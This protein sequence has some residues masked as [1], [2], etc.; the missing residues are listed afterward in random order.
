[1]A[2]LTL[3]SKGSTGG[4]ALIESLNPDFN[5][6]VTQSLRAGVNGVNVSKALLRFDLSS[7]PVNALVSSAILTLHTVGQDSSIGRA[8][9][10]TRGLTQWYEGSAD[11][12]IPT[13]NGSTWSKRNYPFNV[14]WS[15]SVAG[16]QSGVDYVASPSGGSVVIN[17]VGIDYSWTVTA[18][19]QLWANGTVN[20]GWWLFGTTA[21]TDSRK[22]FSSFD[23]TT[24]SQR[25]KLVITYTSDVLVAP[26][27]RFAV[28]GRAGPTVVKGAITKAP[29]ADSSVGTTTGPTVKAG[30]TLT[31]SPA[32][33]VADKVDPNVGVAGLT[34]LGGV[35]S[36]RGANNEAVVPP[37][38]A[39]SL[40]PAP[41]NAKGTTTGPSAVIKG[42]P[43]LTPNPAEA[44]GETPA[45]ASLVDLTLRPAAATAAGETSVTVIAARIY[46]VVCT[47]DPLLYITNGTLRSNGQ[48]NRLSLLTTGFLLNDWKPNISQYKDGGVWS[49]SALA[50]GRTLAR[51]SFANALE[52]MDMR[53]TGKDQ[54]V[55]IAFMQELFAWQELA[56]DYWVSDW[57]LQPVYLVTK[58]AK[59]TNIR[60]ALIKAMSVPELTNPFG[61]PFYSRNNRSVIDPFTL[62][63]ERG[64]WLST[65]P[66]LGDCVN[67]SG[68]R[69]WTVQG[70]TV[71]NTTGGGAA[72]ISGAVLCF[73]QLANGDILAGTN[74]QAQIYRSTN[75]GAS[76]IQIA[77]LGT[78]SDAINKMAVTRAG[79]I[80]AAV[81]GSTAARGIW[82]SP[83][84]GTS[85]A[86]TYNDPAGQGYLDVGYAPGQ[87]FLV[88][89]GGSS[90]AETNN[91]IFSND[92]G[93]H[94][95]RSNDVPTPYG[96][97]AIAFQ[98]EPVLATSYPNQPASA[99]NVQ[100]AGFWGTDGYYTTAGVA[101]MDAVAPTAS[102]T[103]YSHMYTP[104][105][106]Q[107]GNGGLDM[108][109]FLHKNPQGSYYRKALWAV[110]SALDVTDTE[111]WQWPNPAGGFNFGKLATI[112][113]KIFNVLYTDPVA[114]TSIPTQRTIWAGA[115]GE[116]YVSYNNGLTWTLATSAPVNQIRAILRT[117]AGTLITGGDSGEVFVYSGASG[118]TGGG[119]GAID[120]N[121]RPINVSA[122]SGGSAVVN[123]YA[124]GMEETCEDEVY[125]SNKSSFSNITHVLHYNGSTYTELQFATLPPYSLLGTTAV[126]N[127]AA[128]FG[129]KTSD[130]NVP[131]GTF[132]SVIFEISQIA[133]NITVVWEFWNGSAWVSLTV[134]D[135]STGFRIAGVGSVHFTVPVTWATTTVNGVLG[136]W[137]RA[138]ISV[139]GT[140]PVTPIHDS[141]HHR[142]IYTANLPYVEISQAGVT[143][144]LP[145]NAQIRWHNRS[146]DPLTVIDLE[147]DR[148]VCGLRSV[149]R[150]QYFN[151]FLNISDKQIPYGITIAKDVDGSFGDSLRAPT[152]RIL[153]V[154]YSSGGRLNTWND[155]AV[156]SISNTVARDY[157][158]TYRAFVRCYKYG[159][160]TNN[161]QL[162][163]QTSF[164]TGGN[165]T[166]SKA[167]FPGTGNDWEVLDFGQITI[168]TTQV[169]FLSS[170]LGDALSLS[171]QGYCTATGIG[172]SLYD[173]ILIPCDE[174][175]IDS[176]SPNPSSS[177]VAKVKGDS[178][179]DVDSIT[180]PKTLITSINRNGSDQIV[181]RYQAITN[182]P[183]MLQT[184][185][186]QRLW[187]LIM[188]YEGY[189]RAYPE[190]AGSVQAYKQQKYLYARGAS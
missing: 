9:G 135:T 162:R 73:V 23:A 140:N 26:T 69:S 80:V 146:D 10:V 133:E 168:P 93:I 113:N 96:I 34:F 44:V 90:V 134:Q 58:A 6:G 49:D 110:K 97:K 76:W 128:Y 57:G 107:M 72:T 106:G 25:P 180:S 103:P 81:T 132:S 70:W 136:Y 88:A 59:E 38:I 183:A 12:A 190:I 2:V 68:I 149:N 165:V 171:V 74:D 92:E 120:E 105:S 1:M 170:N 39:A 51:R 86:K 41:A 166:L 83:G 31:P 139:V 82:R 11:N 17:T 54:D 172:L 104:G 79:S 118:S 116:L 22:H 71:G 36:A 150:G 62:R 20:N 122:P 28:A 154:S 46:P 137:V 43:H 161:W 147:I 155:L 114:Y 33:A 27:A 156:F 50:E 16:G 13:G 48:L 8:I 109:V 5:F 169:A 124:L 4:D 94:W 112:D 32:S 14:N 115:N 89:V 141:L 179:L 66:G 187:F 40:A 174:W 152:N 15:G 29:T 61:Q 130:T 175:G 77:K 144:D 138:R 123:S 19:V 56:A 84:D 21:D 87:G 65:P 176:R 55:M 42:D 148:M 47:P 189:W 151:S 153:V 129:S 98:E 45:P 24:S 157:Y 143:G 177:N 60:Y 85:W 75:N 164:G 181:S 167:I 78:G 111:I 18:D 63:L 184:K 95:G 163:L 126:V 158:G 117:K 101:W 102:P 100:S 91:I 3:Q 142:Y 182:G 186:Q 67:L 185:R 108:T 37:N 127:K 35:A 7:L 188:S 159:S 53:G 173:L 145:A 131:G 121:G 99:F 119:V 64:P 160:G 178:Y 30:F 125:T 52:V